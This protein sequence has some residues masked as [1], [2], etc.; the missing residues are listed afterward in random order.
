MAGRNP[1]AKGLGIMRQVPIPFYHLT[2]EAFFPR[3]TKKE[4]KNVRISTSVFWY[5]HEFEKKKKKYAKF[6]PIELFVSKENL[7]GTIENL[8][9]N[10]AKKIKKTQHKISLPRYC[11]ECE[12]VGTSTTK[13]DD[14]Y[15]T[16]NHKVRIHYN[17]GKSK[18]YVG[19]YDLDNGSLKPRGKT[20]KKEAI[21]IRKFFITYWVGKR[22]SD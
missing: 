6:V 18:H 17:H 2:F 1:I 15:E 9:L 12:K 3:G 10:G 21:D 22:S 4:N 13:L 16:K 19:T 14:R 20:S 5:V 8:K 7:E 11:P